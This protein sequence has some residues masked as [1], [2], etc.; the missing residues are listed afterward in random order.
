MRLLCSGGGTGGHVYPILTVV[1]ALRDAAAAT[2]PTLTPAPAAKPEPIAIRYAGVPDG[3]EVDL[4]ARAGLDFTPIRAGQVRIHNPLKLVRNSAYLLQG[5]WQARRLIASWRP[6]VVFVTGG[7]ACAPVVWAAHRQHIPI[8]IYL[9]DVTPGLAVQRLARYADQVAVTFPEVAAYFPGKAI[10]TGYP[11]R[12]ELSRR[13]YDRDEARQRFQLDPSIPAVLIFGGSRGSRSIN[14]ATAA[15]LTQ[16][17][18]LAQVIHI[19][20][21]LDWPQAQARTAGLTPEQAARYRL[22][23]YLHEEMTAALC[24]ADL[25]VARAGA[26]TL[27]EFPALG[28]A[29][30]LVP[31]PISGQHQLPNAAYL[32]DRGAALIITDADLPTQLLPAIRTLL[33]DPHRLAAMSQASAA[34]A[35]HDAADRIAAALRALAGAPTTRAST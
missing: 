20:G 11:V 24:A 23:P 13:A 9:P 7:Y 32:A 31:L 28:L 14:Q 17:L 21:D 3:I 34:L 25:V 15:A 16:L 27:G 2:S 1:S 19:T 10:V 8:L 35:Q 22:Y 26:S 12:P 33:H 4:T 30:I 5:A 29:S 6:N 18:E